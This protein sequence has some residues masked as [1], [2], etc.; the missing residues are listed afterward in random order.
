MQRPPTT[1]GTRTVAA[2]TATA[3]GTVGLLTAVLAN[4]GAAHAAGVP[5]LSPLSVPGRGATVPFVEQEAEYAATNGTV[6]GPDRKYG[7]LPSEASG[8]QAVTLSGTGQ[9]V[10]F[11]LTQPANSVDFRY[12][13]PDSA[14][15]RGRDASIDLQVNGSTVKSVP[16]TS[17]YS[18]YYGGYPFNNNPGD[19]NPHHFY[20]ETRTLLGQTYPIGTKIRLQVSSTS[21]SPTFTID[22]ADFENVAA[23]IAKPS[24]ALDVV[25]D[26]GADPTG[27]T[28]STSKFQA[29]VNAGAAQGKTVYIPQGNF[30]LYSHVVVDKV[31]LVGAGPWYS[32]LGGR[33]PINRANAA[34]IYGKYVNNGGSTNVNLKDFAIIGDIRERV[35][36]DQ[37]NAIGGAM[38]NSTI[39]NLWLQH[40]KVGAWMDGPMDRLTIKNSRILDQTADG[41]NFHT[42]VTNSTVTNTFVRNTGD[43]G[44]ASW[45]EN[46]PNTNDS[47]THN[48]VVLPIL[49]NNIVTYGGRDF[50][51]SDNVM[52]DTI[53]NGGGLHI[54]NRYPGVNS[55]SGTAV[56]G[57]ITAARNTLI[58]TGNSDFNWQF[59]V[60]AVWFSG[61]N[62]AISGATINI[63]DTDILD[64]SYEAIQTIE[65]PASGINFTNVNINGAGTYAVQ[66]QAAATMKFTNVKATNIGQ[67]ATPIHNCVGSGF[68]ITDGGGNSGL[69]GSTCSGTWPNPIWTYNGVPSNPG[70]SSP[71]PSPSQPSSPS[72]SPSP[73]GSPTPTCPTGTGN[74]AQG[75]TATSSSSNQS[76]TAANLV[77]GNADTYWE[78]ANNAFPQWAQVDL[79]CAV[80]LSRVTLKLPPATAWNS[81]TET[82]SVQ[83]STDGTTFS[84]LVGSAGYTFDPA[85]GNTATITLPTNT[86][87]Y[88][89]IS[90][91]G[92]TAWPAAQF[93]E[94]QVFLGAGSTSSPTP[95]PSPTTTPTCNPG[96]GNIAQGKPATASSS[97]QNYGAG[98]VV[99]GNADTYWESANNAFPQTLQVDLGCALPLSKVTLKLPPASSWATRTE[100]L[101]VQGST[102]GTTFSTLVGSAGYTFNPATGNTVTVTLPATPTRFVRLSFTGN[103]GWPAGQL[104]EFQVFAS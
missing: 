48:T 37:V 74:V 33:D 58:R 55:G 21:Q 88:L 103:T 2:L 16:V 96:T 18:W 61:L 73:S 94:L 30:T 15:G 44:L 40:T 72:P 78:S 46:K 34:G 98:N 67:S 6:I 70:T 81:R 77:D 68:V 8:R 1:R 83:G 38:S 32:V 3:L 13:L 85:S 86:T 76:Y 104:S 45:P 22:L 50:T 54:A 49:A 91:T 29:A 100:T 84:T 60:G 17:K 42:G 63:T 5:A 79:G 26:F 36:E 4:A 56:A 97:T 14:D 41:V 89:R 87:R 11:T 43:D 24:G 80:S 64:S 90:V 27:A 31:T 93:S 7:N 35:D 92:N 101:S 28:D 99:D 9:Y 12:S 69:T 25:A 59:G 57:T 10:E 51:I 47:F 82:L 71:S 62:E 53:S 39:D 95:S 52:S 20:D 65:G 102:D 19:T 23:P 66:A 75:R